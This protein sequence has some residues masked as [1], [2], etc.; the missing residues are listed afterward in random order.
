MIVM[1]RPAKARRTVGE[2][3]L[4]RPTVVAADFSPTTIPAFTKPMIAMNKPIPAEIAFFKSS[5]IA[6][7]IAVRAPV[8]V[9]R[10]KMIPA[11]NTAA[12]AAPAE[13]PNAP[14]SV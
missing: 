13:S 8:T 12:R 6:L 1:T 2:A 9:S 14:Q 3:K 10:M 5:G 4:P 7:T 11:I